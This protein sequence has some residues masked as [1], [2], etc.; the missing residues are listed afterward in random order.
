M[1]TTSPTA[2]PDAVPSPALPEPTEVGRRRATLEQWWRILRVELRTSPALIPLAALTL[3]GA[4]QLTGADAPWVGYWQNT[5]LKVHLY[6]N[7]VLGIGTAAVAAWHVGRSRTP[8]LRVME[9]TS[10]VAGA[11]IVLR[12]VVPLW[13][14]ATTGFVLLLAGA[15]ARSALVHLGVPAWGLV[16][17]T[18]ALLAMQISFGAALGA[19]LPRR[20][21]PVVTMVLLYGGLAAPVYISDGERTWGRLFPVV[22]QVWDPGM[23]E[24]PLRL[25][26]ASLWLVSAAA[27]FVVL[28][29]LRWVG[30]GRRRRTV[31][32]A[33][34]LA[35]GATAAL[36][37]V[38]Q[39]PRG[40][41]FADSFGPTDPITCTT[42]PGPSFCAWDADSYLLEP[43]AQA[44]AEF[45]R[46]TKGLAYLPQTFGETGMSRRLNR[47]VVEITAFSR[48][49]PSRQE[50]LS[51]F[52]DLASPQPGPSCVAPDG[53]LM[54]VSEAARAIPALLRERLGLPLEPGEGDL[55]ELGQLK[56]LSVQEQNAWMNVAATAE[57][58]C[59]EPPPV[60]TP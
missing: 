13:I 3:L 20:V 42:G 47:P 41:Q 55:A 45:A 50:A 34:L 52:I 43:M 59:H 38:P 18:A 21:A 32:V 15:Y 22:Q 46:A 19:W 7:I 23:R 4:V 30:S 14:L 10:R 8:G 29:G 9:G 49:V 33:A 51:V 17:M 35:A 58:S 60:K 39:V 24:A 31:V 54:G 2:P 57:T 44:S 25:M 27:L 37:L 40:E 11:S 26:T 5:T 12:V 56:K 36:V 6:T 16:V 28:A 48:P 53:N 1:T